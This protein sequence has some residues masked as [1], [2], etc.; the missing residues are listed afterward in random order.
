MR[1]ALAG[2]RTCLC[3]SSTFVVR[4]DL[5][6]FNLND[7]AKAGLILVQSSSFEWL[8]I[9]TSDRKFV[10]AGCCK[11]FSISHICEKVSEMSAKR[12]IQSGFT[13]VE[14]LVVIAII[15][16]LIG[17]LLPAVQQVREAARRVQ[18]ANNLRQLALGTINFESTHGR[19]PVNQVGHGES[20]GMGGHYSW[21]VPVLPFV[22][23]GN[24][25][26]MF[27]L[28]V[29]NGD[30]D[31]FEMSD[32]H[33]NAIAAATEV[34]LF[35][36][37]SDTAGDNTLWLGSANPASSNYAGNIGWPSR[38]SGFDNERSH[39]AGFDGARTLGAF[40]GIIPLENPANPVAWHGNS[41]SGFAQI[42][43]GASNTAMISERLIQTE[44]VPRNLRSG[45]P[46]I[47]SQ[48]I[49]PRGETQSLAAIAFQ[50]L[51]GQDPHAI[52]SAYTGRSWSS[53]Y[54]L[55]APT[56]VHI[57]QPN[58]QL[59]HFSESASQGDFLVS[60]SSNHSGGINLVRADGSVEFVDEDIEEEVWWALGA[61]NDG[62]VNN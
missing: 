54:P 11:L 28:S 58:S 8:F 2:S 30:G 25:H 24:L 14:L 60:P 20:R 9:Y 21:L 4:N 43:D 16:I 22:E 57:L 3:S 42:L 19:F 23:Q 40:N 18:C 55:T 12:R 56:Y 61:R 62:R 13:L 5:K 6:R 52:E 41:K 47:T 45:D 48:H 53:G 59:G 36:C 7:R 38:V 39:I 49:V 29:N 27:D 34:P 33:P 35:L 26:S 10:V 51:N 37:P 32:S 1:A 15:G 50:I 31:G 46:R 44:N 17:M